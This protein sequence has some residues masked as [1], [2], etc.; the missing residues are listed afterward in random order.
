M[1]TLVRS[2]FLLLTCLASTSLARA[3]GRTVVFYEPGF[4]VADSARVSQA[5]LQA[6]F[7]GAAFA[8]A[9]Q[10]PASLADADLLVMPYGSAWP[11]AQWKPILEYL[12]RGGNLLVLGGKPFTRGAWQDSSG[13]HLRAPS[14]AASLELFIHDYQETPGSDGLKF[15]A[16][17]DVLPAL[18]EFSWKRAFSPVLRLSVV[19]EVQPR[20]LD[21]R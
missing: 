18:P 19:A 17:P 8:T 2:I 4:P 14:V 11:E 16:N 12:D 5:Q 13:W 9:T 1:K 10:L 7:A 6:G 15:E 21:R 3:A 20:W